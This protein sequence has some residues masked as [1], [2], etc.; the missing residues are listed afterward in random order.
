GPGFPARAPARPA[1]RARRRRRLG[2]GWSYLRTLERSP[3]P[4]AGVGP[5]ETVWHRSPTP[6]GAAS[7]A[8]TKGRLTCISHMTPVSLRVLAEVACCLVAAPTLAAGTRRTRWAIA[9]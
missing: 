7:G 8:G 1:R 4:A 5:A 9:R 3:T 6:A 2:H